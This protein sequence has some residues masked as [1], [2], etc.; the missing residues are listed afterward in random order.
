MDDEVTAVV[1]AYMANSG[2]G[3]IAF[4]DGCGLD[5]MAAVDAHPFART[6]PALDQF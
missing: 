2:C 6:Q 3:T 5:P 1:N 4:G